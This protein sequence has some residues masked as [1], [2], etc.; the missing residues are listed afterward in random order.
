MRSR[1]GF[2]LI[3]LL[4][5][6]AIIAVLIA[7]LLPAVQAA[8]EAARRSQCVNNLK[9]IGLAMHNYHAT[10][11]ALP[12]PKIYAS[13][14]SYLNDSAGHILNTTGF[15]LILNYMEQST[16]SN[17]YNFSQTSSN[18]VKVNGGP[19]SGLYGDQ[20]VNTTVVGAMVTS[21]VCPS[22]LSP[23]E[24][25]TV[26]PAA[27]SDYVMSNARRSNYLLCSAVYTDYNCPGLGSG[28]NHPPADNQQGMFYNDLA[29]GF[30]QVKDGLSTT[31]MAGE[32]PQAHASAS[33]GPYWGAGTHTSTH[34]TVYPVSNASYLRQMPNGPSSAT[35]KLLYA[36]TMRSHHPG[37]LNMLFGDGS[38]KYIKN[39]ISPVTWW[40]L[41]TINGQEVISSDSF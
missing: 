16:L 8:R 30:A 33:Y 25:K 31:C 39:S 9:Q 13:S 23:P 2:T 7:L 5:V 20:R 19:N 6:I 18:S 17:A 28:T 1:R 14:C 21:F 38:I 4:V 36:W 34:G 11:N 29:V 10:H 24:V 37:G 26:A 12:P 27:N 3:E 22:D 40:G 15:T 32:S 35:S 41:Q